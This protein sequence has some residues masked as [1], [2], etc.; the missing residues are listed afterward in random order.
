MFLVGPKKLVWSF[1]QG[2]LAVLHFHIVCRVKNQ[3]KLCQILG[4]LTFKDFLPSYGVSFG[5][6]APQVYCYRLQLVM[7]HCMVGLP[8][9]SEC[10]E[11]FCCS[12][13]NSV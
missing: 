11:N 1:G 6:E 10:F 7:W 12:L 5:V 2:K 4:N 9:Y 13:Q 3:S 8:Q